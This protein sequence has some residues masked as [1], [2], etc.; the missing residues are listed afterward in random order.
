MFIKK[1]HALDT[2]DPVVFKVIVRSF[3]ALLTVI[4]RKYKFQMLPLQ[5]TV[6]ILFNQMFYTCSLWH[7]NGY[8]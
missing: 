4:F 2:L 6:R 8:I 3:G 5:S 7:S 1:E